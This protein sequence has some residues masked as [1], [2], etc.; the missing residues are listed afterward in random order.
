MP[1]THSSASHA[2]PYA[3]FPDNRDRRV[4]GRT[5]QYRDDSRYQGQSSSHT[6]YEVSQSFERKDYLLGDKTAFFDSQSYANVKKIREQFASLNL[7]KNA[8]KKCASLVI[9]HARE[10]RDKANPYLSSS[11]IDRGA[12]GKNH[13]QNEKN[14]YLERLAV[15][16]GAHA[17]RLDNLTNRMSCIDIAREVCESRCFDEGVRKGEL[18][19]LSMLANVFSKLSY[20][21]DCRNA[22]AKI[23]RE[24][25]RRMHSDARAFKARDL[26]DFAYVFSKFSSDADCA[27]TCQAIASEVSRRI[28]SE[29]EVQIK[30]EAQKFNAQQLTLLVSAFSKFLNNTVCQKAIKVLAGE[31]RRRMESA[32]EAWEFT[33][34]NLTNLMQA[35]DE[36]MV[37][38]NAD[39]P[40]S[41]AC[42]MLAFEVVRRVGSSKAVQEFEAHQLKS[43]MSVFHKFR[44]SAACDDACKAIDKYKT[45]KH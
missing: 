42:E 18:K 26:A 43:L 41:G 25:F 9:R 31:V 45:S 16:T 8:P 40:V 5:R 21:G 30:K 23:A 1:R 37:M 3:R 15:L 7:E 24:V 17:K 19:H 2:Q 6:V 32:K 11:Q 36:F 22:C 14:S 13:P 34:Q 38:H 44:G 20:D 33:A 35:F 39:C 29:A 4:D 27:N 12:R 10:P 28:S